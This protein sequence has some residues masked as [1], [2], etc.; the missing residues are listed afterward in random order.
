M[1]ADP[2][3]VPNYPSPTRVQI[4]R[5][6]AATVAN[7]LAPG[8]GAVDYINKRLNIGVDLRTCKRR[9]VHESNECCKRFCEATFTA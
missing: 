4:R 6:H 7:S 8:R 9:R 2:K 1:S 5:D 3:A